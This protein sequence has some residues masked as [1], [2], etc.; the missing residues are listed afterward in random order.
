MFVQPA[1]IQL[2]LPFVCGL[3]IAQP[4]FNGD[5]TLASAREK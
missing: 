4:A 1:Q 2:H 5:Q 3:E